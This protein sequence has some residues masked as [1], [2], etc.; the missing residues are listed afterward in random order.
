MGQPVIPERSWTFS[1]WPSLNLLR[2]SVKSSF[3]GSDVQNPWSIPMACVALCNIKKSTFQTLD[4]AS[5]SLDSIKISNISTDDL[6]ASS[7][8]GL[9]SQASQRRCPHQFRPQEQLPG[10]RPMSSLHQRIQGVRCLTSCSHATSPRNSFTCSWKHP[11]WPLEA[12]NKTNMMVSQKKT[13]GLLVVKRHIYYI[14]I[15]QSTV[16]DHWKT[17]SIDDLLA[18]QSILCALWS[19][20]RHALTRCPDSTSKPHDLWRFLGARTEPQPALDPAGMASHGIT[21]PQKDGDV[22]KL[23]YA[24]THQTSW[25]WTIAA[26]E[27]DPRIPGAP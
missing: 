14:Y 1:S 9:T 4:Y 6:S 25:F 3:L 10:G 11:R 19:L 15:N 2:P 23:G 21:V 5:P 8:V 24:L 18:Y 7:P 17:I 20:F 13:A 26:T 27:F 12:P 16:Q 22:P